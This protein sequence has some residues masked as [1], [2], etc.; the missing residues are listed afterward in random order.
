MITFVMI[1]IDPTGATRAVIDQRYS[2]QN[3]R[4]ERMGVVVVVACIH[5][6]LRTRN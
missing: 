6:Y 4:V 3:E 2:Y 5:P 1:F